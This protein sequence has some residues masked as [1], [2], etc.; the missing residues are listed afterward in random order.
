MWKK[1]IPQWWGCIASSNAEGTGQVQL[2]GD[3]NNEI[4]YKYTYTLF[5]EKKDLCA[6]SYYLDHLKYSQKETVNFINSKAHGVILFQG[7]H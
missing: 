6:V 1:Y 5:F 4:G 7:S 2:T 3:I